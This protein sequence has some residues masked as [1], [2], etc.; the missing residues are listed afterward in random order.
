MSLQGVEPVWITDYWDGPLQ[1][2]A[3]YEGRLHWF[4]VES[5]NIDDP[6]AMRTYVLYP[7]SDQEIAAEEA[8]HDLFRKHVGT[9]TDWELRGK[10]EAVVHPRSEWAGFYESAEAKRERDYSTRTAIGR[11]TL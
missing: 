11:F 4:E 3:R 7:L 8:L 10:P 2:L 5:F 6:S 9:H 1:G